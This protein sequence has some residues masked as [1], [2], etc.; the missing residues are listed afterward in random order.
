VRILIETASIIDGVTHV[1]L[2][3]G[4]ISVAGFEIDE[5]GN[6]RFPKNIIIPLGMVLK[7]NEKL[8]SACVLA[9]GLMA[10]NQQV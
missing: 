7:I 2:R 8:R 10:K 4:D 6:R 9:K 3:F 1:T 5:H